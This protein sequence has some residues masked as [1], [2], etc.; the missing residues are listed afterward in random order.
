MKV[1]D[2]GLLSPAVPVFRGRLRGTGDSLGPSDFVADSIRKQK[3]I[4]NHLD[5]GQ[6][7][8][9]LIRVTEIVH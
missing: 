5:Y 4:A 3:S 1:E 9:V 2:R 6:G 8:L 7:F